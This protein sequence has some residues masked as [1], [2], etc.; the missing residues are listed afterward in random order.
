[1]AHSVAVRLLQDGISVIGPAIG[2]FARAVSIQTP[3]ARFNH[4]HEEL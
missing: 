3:V 1:M 2:G 4:N